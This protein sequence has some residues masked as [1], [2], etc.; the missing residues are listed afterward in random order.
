MATT[1][2]WRVKG[3]L[4]GVLLYAE[5]P[6]KTTELSPF[7]T[8]ANADLNAMEDVISYAAREDATEERRYVSGVNCTPNNAREVMTK[9]KNEFEK[10]GGTIAY[11]GYQSFRKGEVTPDLAHQ[12]GKRLA[13]ELWG[14]RY[15][16]LVATHVDK[17]SHIHNHFVLNTVSFVDGIK[18]HR[19]KQDYQQMREA[20]DRLCRE[21]GL[22]VIE[23]P[24]G[25]G[26]NY[27]L[28]EAEKNGKPT[29]SNIAR[30]DI[31]RAIAASMSEAEFYSAMASLGYRIETETSTGTMRIHPILIT[32]SNKHIRFDT[33][34]EEY[35][36]DRI[37]ERIYLHQEYAPLTE[38]IRKE[39]FDNDD[40]LNVKFPKRKKYTGLQALY[41]RYCY[42]LHII[43]RHPKN[44]VSFALR[45][46]VIKLDKYI[47]QTYFLADTGITS[48]EQLAAYQ[49]QSEEIRCR[50]EK[51][52][53]E[54]RNALRRATRAG[55]SE[56]VEL[57]KA[58]IADVSAKI[59]KCRKEE[60]LCGEITERSEAVSMAM[61]H[62]TEIIEEGGKQQYDN[63]SRSRGSGRENGTERR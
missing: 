15:E 61:S 23:N 43:E 52:R 7:E 9:T 33:L 44:R 17:R 54:L 40:W 62:P 5:N 18:Y 19:T 8:P 11:H 2:I 30:A 42:T 37:R 26:K 39:D 59:K 28:Y 6:Y 35:S 63:I 3:Y 13:Q 60:S 56:S 16:V 58:G 1:S 55:D 14:D 27:Q 34:G 47:E 32:G 53:V 36:L 25:K 51:K 24:R 29:R 38:A 48:R 10:T 12:I 49:K 57:T 45:E 20:S 46:D 50:L 4:R 41:F 22:S 31:D 21:Y